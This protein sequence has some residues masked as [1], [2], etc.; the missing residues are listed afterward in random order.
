MLNMAL[1]TMVLY[2]ISILC[3]KIIEKK[4]GRIEDDDEDEQAKTGDEAEEP[5]A[6]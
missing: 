5:F 4:Q 2:E 6:S 3:V 1:P